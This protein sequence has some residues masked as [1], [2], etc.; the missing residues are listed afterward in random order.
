MVVKDFPSG[1]PQNRPV[2][3]WHAL[4]GPVVSQHS[5][6]SVDLFGVFCVASEQHF[7][8]VEDGFLVLT[9]RYFDL[10]LGQQVQWIPT[11]NRRRVKGIKGTLASFSSCA[12]LVSHA[13]QVVTVTGVNLHLGVVFNKER[14]LNLVASLKRCW[15]GAAG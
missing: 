15:L 5:K 10:G 12:Q 4:Q 1:K 6:L 3:I 2:K 13:A 8:V 14:D 9:I 11:A 7:G